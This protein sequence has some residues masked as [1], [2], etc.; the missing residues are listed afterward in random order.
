M[1]ATNEVYS[2]LG[3]C[4]CPPILMEDN[5]PV[6][7]TRKGRIE[8]TNGSFQN[9]LHVPKLSFNILFEYQMKNDAGALLSLA[10]RKT[11]QHLGICT[12]AQHWQLQ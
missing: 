4:K 2:S 8:L 3:A 5:S 12:G 9:V 7:V 10:R 1:E 11:H 6:E